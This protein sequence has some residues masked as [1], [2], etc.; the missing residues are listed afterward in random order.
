[1]DNNNILEYYRINKK[2]LVKEMKVEQEKSTE[3]KIFQ[4]VYQH[5]SK[6][7]LCKKTVYFTDKYCYGN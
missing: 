2:L 1:M 3:Y 7:N 4:Q 6:K 5:D